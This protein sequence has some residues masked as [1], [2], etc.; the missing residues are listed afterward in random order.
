M[1]LFLKQGADGQPGAKGE[2]G[3]TGSKGDAGAPGPAGATGAPGPQVQ[4]TYKAHHIYK[5]IRS[6]SKHR[7]YD[8]FFLLDTL[9]TVLV[10]FNN[11]IKQD[12]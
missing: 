1:S 12:Q 7:H 10:L 9:A 3:D 11:L 6:N 5:C 8:S 2:A 4:A